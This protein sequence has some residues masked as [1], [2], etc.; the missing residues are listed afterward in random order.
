MRPGSEPVEFSDQGKVEYEKWKHIP[1]V[2][3]SPLPADLFVKQNGIF[4]QSQLQP[5]QIVAVADGFVGLVDEFPYDN[6]VDPHFYACC[7]TK[8]VLDT[9]KTAPQLIHNFRRSLSPNCVVKLVKCAGFCYAGVFAGV[10]DVNGIAKRTRREKFPIPANTE[11]LL[12]IDFAPATI[13][14]PAEFMSWHFDEIEIQACDLISSPATTSPPKHM[15]PSRDERDEM[16]VIRQVDKAKK[17]KKLRDDVK[18]CKV[19]K[20]PGKPPRAAKTPIEVVES[21]LFSL[22]KT[23]NP[24]PYLFGLPSPE[25]DALGEFGR[26]RDLRGSAAFVGEVDCGFLETLLNSEAE[27]FVPP[28]AD[29]PIPQMMELVCFGA[30]DD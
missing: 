23:A 24:E 7:G 8:F 25:D 5:E 6:G 12:P 28:T 2:I 10:S 27:P 22:I 3:Q 15:R 14:E 19:K 1:E 21:S 26:S 4:C 30:F 17:K 11:L 18:I 16:A 9:R 29:D 20:K 13:E